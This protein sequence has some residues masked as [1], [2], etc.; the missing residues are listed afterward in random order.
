MSETLKAA[1]GVRVKAPP[2]PP[3]PRERPTTP[4]PLVRLDWLT[5]VCR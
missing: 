4:L 5:G 1:L 3:P 2:V